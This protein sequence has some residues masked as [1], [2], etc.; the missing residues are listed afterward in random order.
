[1]YRFYDNNL[2]H[3]GLV[4]LLMRN[5]LLK[6]VFSTFHNVSNKYKKFC[7]L[8]K[9]GNNFPVADYIERQTEKNNSLVM[10]FCDIFVTVGD[11][12]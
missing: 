11:K 4:P 6:I 10:F 12:N 1:M 8:N 2:T 9:C 3:K 7:H 5:C